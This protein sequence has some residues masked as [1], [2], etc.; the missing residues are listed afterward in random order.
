[1]SKKKGL[2]IRGVQ[3]FWKIIEYLRLNTI[4]KN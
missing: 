4:K 3:I 2:K 1:M